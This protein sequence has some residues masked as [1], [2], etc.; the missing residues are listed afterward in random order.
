MKILFFLNKKIKLSY[1]LYCF[2]FLILPIMA[3]KTKNPVSKAKSYYGAKIDSVVTGRE[4]YKVKSGA[5]KSGTDRWEPSSKS[6]GGGKVP[7]K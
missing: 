3:K 2:S 5:Y 7:R 6:T 4:F 1:E